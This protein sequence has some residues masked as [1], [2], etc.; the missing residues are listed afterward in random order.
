M[1]TL[2]PPPA[3]EHRRTKGSV[4][5]GMADNPQPAIPAGDEAQL[6]ALAHHMEAL[7]HLPRTGWVDRGIGQPESVAAHSWRLALL[8]WLLADRLGL[9]AGRAM[10][11]ALV[12]DLPEAITGDQLPY[13]DEDLSAEERQRLV[14]E[15]PEL[16]EW[17]TADRRA[18]KVALERE[19]LR[20]ILADA[21]QAAARALSAAW[22][23]YEDASSP[24]ARLVSQLDKLEAYLQ[25]WEYA[26]DGRL[27]ESRTLGSFREDTDRLVQDP[28]L[29]AV[30]DA[31]EAWASTAPQREVSEDS[32]R[33]RGQ[34][35]QEPQ[36][37]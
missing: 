14:M 16:A 9:D 31:L 17:R 33:A 6:L 20:T 4:T 12:H 18:R 29:R 10:R 36:H 24:E 22:E 13:A 5:H 23:E 37:R 25:G 3:L 8:A 30:L 35:R 32:Q 19:A 34:E 7:K 26:R 21:P 28:A 1:R 27:A 15:P 11:L 2:A